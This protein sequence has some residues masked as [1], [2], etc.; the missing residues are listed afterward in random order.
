MKKLLMSNLVW[1]GMS[2]LLVAAAL[3]CGS[4]GTSV[5][6]PELSPEDQ[7]AAEQSVSQH[8]TDDYAKS[9]SEQNGQRKR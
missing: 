6:K 2:G 8:E 3:G 7:M 5:V 1:I 4:A 9:M